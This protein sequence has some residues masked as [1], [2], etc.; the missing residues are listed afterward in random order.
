MESSPRSIISMAGMPWPCQTIATL[1]WEFP[2]RWQAYHNFNHRVKIIDRLFFDHKSFLHET[3]KILFWTARLRICDVELLNLIFFHILVVIPTRI[4][5][6]MLFRSVLNQIAF[7]KF[8]SFQSLGSTIWR[9]VC[10]APVYF[11]SGDTFCISS[12]HNGA[13]NSNID[14]GHYVV[15]VTPDPIQHNVFNDS[16]INFSHIY[17]V[18]LNIM[19]TNNFLECLISEK[20]FSSR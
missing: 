1:N 7:S 11:H 15:R 19:E 12:S 18:W 17:F 9:A 13:M 2:R 6:H 10:R 5:H 20:F 8:I 3:K 14:Y 4:G 16:T